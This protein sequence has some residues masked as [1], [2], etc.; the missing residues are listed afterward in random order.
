MTG[1]Q[2]FLAFGMLIVAIISHIV[3]TVWWASSITT[4]LRFQALELKRIGQQ[5]GSHDGKFYDKEEARSQVQKRDKEVS[6]IQNDVSKLRDR[7]STIEGDMRNQRGFTGLEILGVIA[8]VG[9]VAILSPKLNPFSGSADPANR[10]TASAI[11]GRDIIDI[12]KVVSSSEEPVT[13]HVDRS[14]TAS[15]EVTDPKLTLGQR[16]GRFFSGLGT[17]AVVGLALALGLG[18]VT[19]AGL[20]WQARSAW[21]SAFKNTVAGVRNLD[22][23]TYQKVVPQLAAMQDQRDKRLVDRVKA[24]LH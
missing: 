15:A 10:R 2:A 7:V 11:S 21:K 1:L 3:A 4:T 6:D 12:T 20:A 9:L 24:E 23:E 17:W 16:V 22:D 8:V 14:V 13:V 18:I 5:L 19:P